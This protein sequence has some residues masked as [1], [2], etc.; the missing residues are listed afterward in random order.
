MASYGSPHDGHKDSRGSAQ[1]NPYNDGTSHHNDTFLSR[2]FGLNSIYNQLEENYQYYDPE[3]D[4]TYNQEMLVRSVQEDQDDEEQMFPRSEMVG[5]LGLSEQH[6]TT[7]QN[8][9][10]SVGTGGI[11]RNGTFNEDV[12]NTSSNNANNTNLLDSESDSDL[13]SSPSPSPSQRQSSP[14][15]KPRFKK[16]GRNNNNEVSS[17][18]PWNGNDPYPEDDEENDL[19]TSLIRPSHNTPPKR[20]LKFNVSNVNNAKEFIMNKLNNNG[21]SANS[22]GLPLYNNHEAPPQSFRKPPSQKDPGTNNANKNAYQRAGSKNGNI[23]FVIPPKERALYLWANI[24]NMDE[25]LTDIYYYYRGKG[26]LN[27]VLSRLIDLVILIFILG[28][29][30]FL[31]W[32]INYEFFFD[33]YRD[34]THLTLNDLIIENFLFSNV[35][36]VVK[37]ILFGFV[38]YIILRLVQLYFDY[39]YKLKEIKNFYRYLINIPNDDELMTISWKT[40]VERLMLLKDYNSLTSTT[41]HIDQSNDHYINDLN[42]KV[43][44]NAHDIANRI[45]R[46]ENYLIALINK[47]VIDLSSNLFRDSSFQLMSNKSVLTKT[48]EW[49]L[50]LCIN[51]FA[52]NPQGQIN[53]SILKDY[54][55]NQLA[56]ELSSR[57]KMAAI[58][59]L[60]LCPFIVIY[61]VL[62]YFFRYF[63]EYKSNPSSIMGLREFTPYAEWKLREFNEL[64]HFFI[65]RLQMSVG[66]SNTYI[67]QFPRGFLVINVMNL[68]NFVSGAIMAILVI[69]GLW[70]EDENHSFWSFEITEGKSSLFYISL[71]GTLWAVTSTSSTSDSVENLNS[72]SSSFV[73]DPEASLRYV[74]QFTHYLPSS[75]NKRLHTVEV[76]NEFCELYSLKILIIINEILSLI[77]TPF[78]LW[79]KVSNNSGAIIDF[80]REYSVHVDGLGYVCYFAMFNFEEKDKNMMF[81]LNKKKKRKSRRSKTHSKQSTPAVTTNEIELNKLKSTR[82]DK[83]KISDSEEHSSNNSSD[84]ESD[85]DLNND[86]YQDEKM[87][88]SYM[89]FLESYGVA[90]NNNGTI[91]GQT[92]PQSGA[93]QKF[94][95]LRTQNNTIR[96]S[97]MSNADPTPSLIVQGGSS[98]TQGILDSTYNI[99]YK[100][101]DDQEETNK[102]GKKS[103]VL[104]MLNQFYKQDIH[105]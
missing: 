69:M 61:F 14:V 16:G 4:S 79:F 64:P 27:I 5:N 47:D 78:L 56:K 39:N 29:T 104:G 46:K 99:N 43:R 66:P 2:I 3:F 83:A 50:K 32:G 34:S 31:K 84:D 102:S 71:F 8:N 93:Q 90:N 59:N 70:F 92:A 36:L 101:D 54:N 53:S 72:N 60:I 48:L 98:D 97:V 1:G 19:L 63:N 6:T 23:R 10:P 35:P 52:F 40:I 18:I 87:I 11:S 105:R 74:S 96:N 68:V 33:N 38:N 21:S 49:N 75:W 95:T 86:Y 62:L 44:L 22:N 57:F 28:F 41:P 80:F 25:F 58:I 37:F 89:Y 45:M 24:T 81:D 91:G 103:G 15:V 20:T 30:V 94:S 73:Y 17:G 100:L 26:L 9:H 55:R 13:S 82:R 77:L 12:I 42:S 65:R 76:K 88:K 85:N 67:N 51:N 7:F